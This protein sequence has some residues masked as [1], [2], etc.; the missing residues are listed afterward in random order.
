VSFAWEVNAHCCRASLLR[1]VGYLT[2]HHIVKI[3]YALLTCWFF[4]CSNSQVGDTCKNEESCN[5]INGICVKSV[6]FT[7]IESSDEK[8]LGINPLSLINP[9]ARPSAL[10]YCGLCRWTRR[11]DPHFNFYLM[12]LSSQKEKEGPRGGH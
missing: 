7:A 5:C 10:L 12:L 9:R 6:K 1:S 11:P 3:L 2:R 4:Y 8:I